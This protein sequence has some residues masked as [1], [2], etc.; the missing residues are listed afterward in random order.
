MPEESVGSNHH[1]YGA[2]RVARGIQSGDTHL[3]RG[4][5]SARSKREGASRNKL[6]QREV[7]RWAN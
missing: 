4:L 2:D 1:P 6:T 5:T 3:E 7:G